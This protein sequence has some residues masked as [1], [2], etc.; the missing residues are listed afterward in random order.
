[1]KK[2]LL[3]TTITFCGVFLAFAQTPTK[4]EKLIVDYMD[5][6]KT[7]LRFSYF[8]QNQGLINEIKEEK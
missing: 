2:I 6:T 8:N 4:L 1:M 7:E 5:G 3:S